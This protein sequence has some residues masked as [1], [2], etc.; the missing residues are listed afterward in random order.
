MKIIEKKCPNCGANLEYKVG[1]RDVR[2]KKCRRDFAV[3]YDEN[4]VDPE[5]YLKAKDI[6]LK[7]LDGFEK[8]Q[9]FAKVFFFIVIA[10]IVI[11]MIGVAIGIITQEIDS[12][13]RREEAERKQAE[14]EQQMH[15]QQDFSEGEFDQMNEE[16]MRQMEEIQRQMQN[17]NYSGAGAD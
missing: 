9:K 15:D 6:Q 3:E 1:E 5:V 17:N 4:I 13:K 7:I 8:N 16:I 2:C 12:Q 11:S 14:F 10:I